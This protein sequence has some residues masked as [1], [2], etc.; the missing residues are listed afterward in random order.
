MGHL[1]MKITNYIKWATLALL[2]AFSLN[3]VGCEKD[4]PLTATEESDNISRPTA[5]AANGKTIQFLSVGEQG[6]NSLNKTTTGQ[7]YVDKSQGGSISVAAPGVSFYLRIP[8]NSIDIS[9]TVT[10]TY[11][12]KNFQGITDLVFGPHGTHFS[13]PALLY[14]K[15]T[16]L[17]LKGV[18]PDKV[19]FY[20]VNDNGQWEEMVVQ[21]IAVYPAHGAVKIEGA[22]LP[23][24]SRYAVASE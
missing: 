15:I 24:F 23:H 16:G 19:K 22:E 5:V 18:N 3:F 8:E 6:S 1:K 20:Y 11:D 17:N 14:A 4:S 21:S 2:T 9:K 13:T 10:M 12:D 7:K